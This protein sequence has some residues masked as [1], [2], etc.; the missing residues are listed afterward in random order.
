VNLESYIARYLDGEMSPSESERF[1]RRLSGSSDMQGLLREMI[2]L[3]RAAR[4]MPVLH[5]P[6]TH[7]ESALFGRLHQ[8]GLHADAPPIGGDTREDRSQRRRRAVAVAAPLLLL[9][10]VLGGYF[11]VSDREPGVA[12][13]NQSKSMAFSSGEN[14]PVPSFDL[15]PAVS[16]NGLSDH[17]LVNPIAGPSAQLRRGDVGNAA[18]R[19]R[20][21]YAPQEKDSS[22]DESTVIEGSLPY[23]ADITIPR[24]VHTLDPIAVPSRS[25]DA[26]AYIASQTS[27]PIPQMLLDYPQKEKRGE[28]SAMVASLN[29]GMTELSSGD[30]IAMRDVQVRLGLEFGSGDRFMMIVGSSANVTETRHENMGPVSRPPGGNGGTKLLLAQPPSPHRIDVSDDAWLGIGYQRPIIELSG[31]RLNLGASVGSSSS[32]LRLGGDLSLSRKL[33]KSIAV[34]LSGTASQVIP[35]DRHV[36]QFTLFGSPDG[37]V[38]SGASQRS[39]FY[40][41]GVQAGVT[42]NLSH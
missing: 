2:A 22:S 26:S 31:V 38:Y 20:S 40:S 32:A 25:F 33:T 34:E 30:G 28:A 1:S 8:E 16:G 23:A 5:T 10:I 6:S 24:E 21:T 18:A 11:G 12:G 13:G 15:G 41:Y 7:L 29:G 35:Y 17:L 3:R 37:Y 14:I 4:R 42:V 36:E 27:T 19:R 39:T 9:V